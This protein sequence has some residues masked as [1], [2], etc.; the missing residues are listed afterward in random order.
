MLNYYSDFPRSSGS[1]LLSKGSLYPGRRFPFTGNT[2]R[3]QHLRVSSHI[4]FVILLCRC[5]SKVAALLIG[6]REGDSPATSVNNLTMNKLAVTT[7]CTSYYAAI[8]RAT[9]ERKR[10]N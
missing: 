2:F 1:D 8:N 7:V 5:F 3:G 10:S 4:L 6:S 9:E